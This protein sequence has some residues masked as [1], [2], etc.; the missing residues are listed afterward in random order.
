MGSAVLKVN[1]NSHLSEGRNGFYFL[2]FLAVN[3]FSFPCLYI[4]KCKANKRQLRVSAI[5]K[6]RILVFYLFPSSNLFLFLI[7]PHPPPHF[8]SSSHLLP[9][10]P[11]TSILLLSSLPPLPLL[12]LHLLSFPLS[13]LFLLP[14]TAA[15]LVVWLRWSPPA[16][17]LEG[18]C[19]FQGVWLCDAGVLAWRD[20]GKCRPGL[21]GV[22]HSLTEYTSKASQRL[23]TTD[24]FFFPANSTE[25]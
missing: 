15:V 16:K 23:Y 18:G 14:L 25:Y 20:P 5:K 1:S 10:P 21:E 9:T 22:C 4:I 8:F 6:K 2:L 13:L 17:F 11:Q 24:F 3:S 12:L 19:T 7:P